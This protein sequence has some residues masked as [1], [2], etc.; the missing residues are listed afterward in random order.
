M[1]LPAVTTKFTFGGRFPA[2]LI[3]A[4]VAVLLSCAM[5]ESNRG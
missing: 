3:G 4:N 5:S 2:S 1:A